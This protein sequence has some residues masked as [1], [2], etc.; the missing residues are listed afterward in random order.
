MTTNVTYHTVKPKCIQIPS[1][2]LTLSQFIHNRLE[3]GKKIWQELRAE[4]NCVWKIII[5]LM[6]DNS[7]RKVYNELGWIAVSFQ[8]LNVSTQLDNTI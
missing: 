4:L 3:N 6:A 2:F 1:T 8:L 5:L 7:D